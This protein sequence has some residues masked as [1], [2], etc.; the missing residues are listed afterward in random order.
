M[1]Y[2]S[3]NLSTLYN[4][5]F[6]E[7]VFCIMTCSTFHEIDDRLCLQIWLGQYFAL[8]K[9]Y[10]SWA[11]REMEVIFLTWMVQDLGALAPR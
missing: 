3:Q 9:P 5:L 4:Y 6:K 10:G 7:S 8:V 1:A 2:G 11:A